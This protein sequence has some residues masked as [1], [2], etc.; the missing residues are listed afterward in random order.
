METVKETYE[1]KQIEQLEKC[2]QA[3]LSNF[4]LVLIFYVFEKTSSIN[5]LRC[6]DQSAGL[7]TKLFGVDQGSLKK[8]LEFVLGKKKKIPPRKR[9][10]ILNRFDEATDFFEE[11][12]FPKGITI[13]SELQKKILE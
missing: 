3:Q 12:V 6:D 2:R 9:T 4:A 8:N 13:L 1:R 11:M 10:E 7:L 5:T